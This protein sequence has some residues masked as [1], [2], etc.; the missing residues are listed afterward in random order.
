MLERKVAHQRRRLA[1]AESSSR[2]QKAGWTLDELAHWGYQRYS[3]T[4]THFVK[5]LLF[6]PVLGQATLGETT[7]RTLA[8]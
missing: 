4:T 3:P 7:W 2:L 1:I 6:Q 5:H 8:G